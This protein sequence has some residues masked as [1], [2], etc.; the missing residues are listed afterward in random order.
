ML[1]PERA[2]DLPI[3]FPYGLAFSRDF[4]FLYCTETFGFSRIYRVQLQS[5]LR[6]SGVCRLAGAVTFGA[7]GD[8][9]NAVNAQFLN[10]NSLQVDTAGNLYVLDGRNHRLRKFFPNECRQ[11]NP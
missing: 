10:P 6:Q 5:D 9:E 2:V 4:Q 8:G 11:D 1:L 7:A 3:S